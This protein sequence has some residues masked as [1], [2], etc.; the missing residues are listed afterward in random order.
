MRFATV[1]AGGKHALALGSDGKL[2]AWGDN[3][4]GQLGNGTTTNSTTPIVVTQPADS[5]RFTR[6]AAGANFSTAIAPALGDAYPSGTG[7]D[8]RMFA[9]GAGVGAGKTTPTNVKLQLSGTGK[10]WSQA[11]DVSAQ[12]GGSLTLMKR[13]PFYDG[14]TSFSL[15]AG[16][17]FNVG[18]VNRPPGSPDDPE[19]IYGLDLFAGGSHFLSASAARSTA[20]A[21]A[22]YGYG[23]NAYGQLGDGTTTDHPSYPGVQVHDPSPTVGFTGMVSAGGR[24]NLAV[25]T[26]EKTYAWG[27]NTS[28]QLGDETTSNRLEPV[29]VHAPAGVTFR[30]IDAGDSHNL[31]IGSDGNAYAWGDNQHGQLGDGTTTNRGKPTRVQTILNITAITFDTT[32]G[33]TPAYDPATGDW[34]TT[35]PAHPA[36]KVNAT[37]DWT[38]NGTPQTSR[39]LANGYEY[40]PYKTITFTDTGGQPLN[41]AIP[42]QTV[43]QGRT[44]TQPTNPTR[45]NCAFSGWYRNNQPFFFH[46]TITTDTT[47]E[48][49]W[50]CFTMT[51]QQGA[52]EGGTTVTITPPTPPT[53][54]RFTHVQAGI[55]TSA[56]LGS[57]GN[58]YMWGS[59]DGGQ[60]GDNAAAGGYSAQ[61]VQVQAPQGVHFTS[62]KPGSDHTLGLAEDG[63]LWAWGRSVQGELG[64]GFIRGTGNPEWSQSNVP[65]RVKTPP[66]VRFTAISAGAHTSFAIGDDGNTYAW[67]NGFYYSSV[68]SNKLSN[69]LPVPVSLPP[70][71]TFTDI[72]STIAT[73]VALGSDGKVYTWGTG[74]AGANGN[75]KT[76]PTEITHTSTNFVPQA[77]STPAGVTFTQI[78][79]NAAANSSVLALDSN[80][81]AWGWGR[82][83]SGMTGIGNATMWIT[84]PTRVSAPAG[85]TFTSVSAGSRHGMFT[86][87]D[88]NTYASG[89]GSITGTGTNGFVNVLTP[90][91]VNTPTGVTLTQISAGNDYT[92]AIGSDGKTYAWGAGTNGILGT[93]GTDQ[94]PSPAEVLPPKVGASSVRFDQ[95]AGLNLTPT[96]DGKYTVVTPAHPIGTVDTTIT[97]TLGNNPQ[98][99]ATL[100]FEYV[101]F[102]LPSAGSIPLHQYTGGSLLLLTTLATITYT[103][104]QFTTRKHTNPHEPRI[105]T[106][107]HGQ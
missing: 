94:K 17:P 88:G 43:T 62:V 23:S 30:A 89:W 93:G 61:P 20:T 7:Y 102:I 12:G 53:G 21:V 72:A 106:S 64:N 19:G 48:A 37:I 39:T 99:N 51:P 60:L 76:P 81:N 41:P 49:R 40:L 83:E 32:P 13:Y 44:T 75:G 66:N 47:L 28:G 77:I 3:S 27:A 91:R 69:V 80:G 55:G 8:F 67:G 52:K 14:L 31:A 54:T 24:H 42:D 56:A 97:W 26:D 50:S 34:T 36:G 45:K 100:P 107:T 15:I 82:N 65:K 73:T 63:T 59:D 105:I 90:T 22:L 78:S 33:T 6:I 92:L 74:Q 103:G 2:Y 18:G 68:S 25:G 57:D 29:E 101:G 10:D 1:K 104:Y 4:S 5:Q 11:Q 58:A 87:S 9:W 86:G 38:I 79:T 98:D 70:N 35:T 16:Y 46:Q 84:T 95:S 71:V 96:A 85:L